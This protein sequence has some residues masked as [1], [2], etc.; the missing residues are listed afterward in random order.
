MTA[1]PGAGEPLADLLRLQDLDLAIDQHRHRRAH[2]SERSELADLM[3][4]ASALE[5]DLVS[6]TAARDELARRQAGVESELA[7]TEAR[8]AS[9]NRR[10][11]SG[12]V[13]A[14]RELKAM[15]DDVE[16]LKSRASALEDQVLELLEE[17]D[18]LDKRVS[19]LT[20]QVAELGGRQAEVR[21]RLAAAEAVVDAELGELQPQRDAAAGVVPDR[22]L[23]TYERL[24]S[25]L[26]GI[27]VARVVGNHCDG[28]H[29]T[30]SAV[31][32]DRIRH[33]PPGEAAT[34]EQ[35]SRILIP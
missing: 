33:L 28:C 23:S 25:R 14:S 34:C 30:L 26:G 27:G 15:A 29:L 31:E 16:S 5:T 18:P 12:E 21:D 9:V 35:C 2:L 4:Q 6:A 17:R 11:Y 32:L 13:S 8:M 7:A 20:D 22:L 10:L 24:R 19:G 3:A 1:E